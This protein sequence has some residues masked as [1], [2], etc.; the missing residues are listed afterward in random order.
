MLQVLPELCKVQGNE[1]TVVLQ[2]DNPTEVNSPEATRLAI[3]QAGV[4]GLP[5]A[6]LSNQSG[7]YPVDANGNSDEAL[8]SG[9]SG[10][11]TGYRQDYRLLSSR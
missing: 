1:A 4:L 8:C 11:V 6:G 9:Q 3:K 2:G 10:T 7:P 5:L